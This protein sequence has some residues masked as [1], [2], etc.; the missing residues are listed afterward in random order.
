MY[1]I[2]IQKITKEE[3]D[4]TDYRLVDKNT[5]EPCDWNDENRTKEHYKTGKVLVRTDEEIIYNQTLKNLNINE[6]VTF[7]NK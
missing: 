5:G 4:E 3:F 1:R 7:L 6:V 2:R